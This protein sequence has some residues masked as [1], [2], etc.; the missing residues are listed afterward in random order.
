MWMSFVVIAVLYSAYHEDR[1]DPKIIFI[2]IQL[3]LW[4]KTSAVGVLY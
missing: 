4:R 2:I 3:N 1:A